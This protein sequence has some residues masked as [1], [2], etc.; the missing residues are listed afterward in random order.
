[1]SSRLFN[2]WRFAAFAACLSVSATAQ[3][4]SAVGNGV[5]SPDDA[6][7]ALLVDITSGQVL[8]ARNADRR[9]APASMTKT[10]TAFVAFE[11][12]ASGTLDPLQ[13]ITVP[14][15]V[16]EEW[17]GKG[18][19]ML[20]PPDAQVPVGDL[21]AGIATVSANDGSIVLAQG[22]SGSV[23]AWLDEMN[24]TARSLG[25][26]N[27]HFGTP[28]G[29]PDEGYTFTTAND[30]ILLA[31]AMIERHPQLY[32][33]YIGR[34]S[35]AYN[36]LS[37][38]NR[39]PLLG[40]TEGADGIKTGFTN[41]AGFGFLG[42][43]KRDD[44]RLVMVLAGVNRNALRARLSRQ[45]I[46]W[47]FEAYE[48]KQLLR[49]N[50]IVGTARVQGGSARSVG[51]TTDRDVFVNIPR[52]QTGTIEY[53]ITYDGPVRAPIKQGDPIAQL[54]ISAEG[55]EPAI[56]PLIAQD[57]VETAGFAQRVLN[58]IAGWFG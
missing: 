18:S 23:P 52:G 19:S 50:A 54:E 56:V 44:Q 27:S 46:E 9:F 10:M 58:G 22:V 53:K 37:Q 34:P 1:M 4:Q 38:V 32:S 35:F 43:A 2:S 55:I 17:Y 11:R 47:G 15:E 45:F 30:L 7:V 57:S 12:I 31:T 5:P 3:T 8:F 21:L 48:R 13:M 14:A 20:L 24:Q 16:S 26:E 40:R 49:E 33:A 39:D 51:L 36:G 6:P 41:E 28:N 42:T 25:M 29:W